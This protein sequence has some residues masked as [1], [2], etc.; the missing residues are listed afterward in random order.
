[1]S[2]SY[3]ADIDGLRAVSILLVVAYHSGLR[4]VGGGYVGVDVFFVISG[5][6]ITGLLLAELNAVGKIS[7]VDFFVR[8]IRRIL[9]LSTL[10]LLVTLVVGSLV[11][12]P[13]SRSAFFSD[14]RSSALFL[15]NWRF[16]GKATSYSDIEVTESLLNHWW[17]LSVEEQFYLF[18][19]VLL[20]VA[21]FLS[22]GRPRRTRRLFF[23]AAL[24]LFLIS[25]SSSIL[26][27]EALGPEAYY[28]S[29]TRLWE[30][31]AGGL[32][33]FWMHARLPSLSRNS[34]SR[35][36][37]I[38]YSFASGLGVL[39]IVVA[40][41]NFDSST[42]FP[43][44][45]GLVPVGGAV[46]VIAFGSK[47]IVGGLLS[48]RPLV[49]VGRRSFGWYLWHWPF[50]GL[51]GLV[52]EDSQFA[53]N[54]LAFSLAAVLVALVVA[55]LTFQFVEEPFRKPKGFLKSRRI[56]PS[57]LCM[58]VTA[59]LLGSVL[60]SS[61]LSTGDGLILVAKMTELDE[62]GPKYSGF[63]GNRGDDRLASPDVSVRPSTS[64]L[65]MSLM[66]PAEAAEDK[67][68]LPGSRVCNADQKE[69][70]IEDA[71][72]FGD[73][74]GNKTVVIIG[75]SHAQHWLP[76]LDSAGRSLHWKIYSYTKS[77]CP[78][79]DVRVYNVRFE[80]PYV[81]CEI[82]HEELKSEISEISADL[83]V[84]VNTHGYANL[85]IGNGE[86]R[87]VDETQVR[88]LWE[89]ASR[90]TFERLLK[91]AK[92]V[93]RLRDTPW[94]AVENVP[95]CLVANPANIS[96]CSFSTIERSNLD[97]S[98]IDAEAQAVELLEDKD[99]V[100][101]VDPTELVC[102]EAMC[103][104]VTPEGLIVYRDGHHFTQRY[105][106]SISDELAD[107]LTPFLSSET[108]S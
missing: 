102:P 10:V 78:A 46:L 83:L 54:K 12:E 92:R 62:F 66:S 40:A 82:W 98:L 90:A 57:L 105:S 30:L 65:Q 31:A 76:A 61:A 18:W 91:S 8:R 13:L 29:H 34:D 84:L 106:Y 36:A 33:A 108:G 3:R 25:L 50:L 24:L 107:L 74:S 39:L 93:V 14:A 71:C 59:P 56:A 88:A 35:G 63:D 96:A 32:L 26:L 20:V 49:W 64:G 73:Y 53:A 6:L 100:S 55:H 58:A 7:L 72:I 95:A 87:V 103:E 17:S 80:R 68:D 21:M 51:T 47:G 23:L 77:A 44:M 85:L 99:L 2:N 60:L 67:I 11:I 5:F 70:Q 41:L 86:E 1:M 15:S 104:V 4:V 79:I 22:S 52:V 9:P 94:P 42:S 101:F 38:R 69:T 97:Q 43:G 75:D 16:A 19:P 89:T 81:E 37:S 28:V 27:T 48:L 45:A